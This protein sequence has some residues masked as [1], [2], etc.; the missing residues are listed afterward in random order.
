MIIE[1][2]FYQIIYNNLRGRSEAK[3]ELP[4]MFMFASQLNAEMVYS[5]LKGITKFSHVS[6]EGFQSNIRSTSVNQ[7]IN[8]IFC[9]DGIDATVSFDSIKVKVK[10]WSS[11]RQEDLKIELVTKQTDDSENAFDLEKL[12][13]K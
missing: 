12:N 11:V 13:E 5:I 1:P 10:D 9:N 4:S 8:P 7:D 3:A 2:G 6:F